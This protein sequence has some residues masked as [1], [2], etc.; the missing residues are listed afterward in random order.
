MTSIVLGINRKNI[1]IYIY[2]IKF[3]DKKLKDLLL[4]SIGGGVFGMV[5]LFNFL[6]SLKVNNYLLGYAKFLIIWEKMIII[7]IG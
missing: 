5:I 4:S 1:Y 2:Y 7:T 3:I 6:F